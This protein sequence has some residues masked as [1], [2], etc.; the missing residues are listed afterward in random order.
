MP[1]LS[2]LLVGDMDRTE[3]GDVR[4][5]LERWGMVQRFANIDAAAATIEAG[6]IAPD[7]MVIAQA[8]PGQFSH[9]S[10]ERLR[11]L[12]PLARVLGLM[13][14]WC[15]GEM[16]SGEPWTA[17]RTYWHQWPARS[18]RELQRLADGQCGA[19]ALPPT[20]TEEE[21]L[22]ADGGP[23]HSPLPKEQ[24]TSGL[25]AIRS[26]SSEM[27]EW[28]LAACRRRG[29][30]TVRQRASFAAKVDGATAAI[31]DGVDLSDEECDELRRWAAAL[32]PAPVYVLLGFPRVEHSRRALAAGAAAVI[33]KPLAL[34]DLFQYVDAAVA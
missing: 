4:A 12:A 31:F 33:S 2:I 11:R 15:E 26:P 30:A 24:G 8:F 27:A 29:Y 19:W 21:R 13:G 14:S 32:R 1:A 9:L 22:L 3:F 18:R 16:R 23:H 17:V 25:V 28:L 6:R 34:D 7:V 20:A 10:I 5:S